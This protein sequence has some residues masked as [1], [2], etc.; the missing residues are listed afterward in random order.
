MA[1][2]VDANEE[3]LSTNGP[4]DPGVDQRGDLGQ[5]RC[6]RPH[7][8]ER[9]VDLEAFRSSPGRR[10]AGAQDRLDAP[11]CSDVVPEGGVRWT[12]DGDQPSTRL[13]DTERLFERRAVL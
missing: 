3:I 2:L 11:T 8:E 12:R 9:V 13:Q 6:V 4:S 1:S 5:L 10:A 7:E